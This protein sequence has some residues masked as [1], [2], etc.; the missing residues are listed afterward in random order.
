VGG[1]LGPANKQKPRAGTKRGQK[2]RVHCTESLTAVGGKQQ[3]EAVSHAT[4][5]APFA[6]KNAKLSE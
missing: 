4:P 3:R 6:Q 1:R 5:R 2:S